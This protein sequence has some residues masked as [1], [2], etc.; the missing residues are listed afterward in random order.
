MEEDR[1]GQYKVGGSMASRW[2]PPCMH[3]LGSGRP[4]SIMR[5]LQATGSGPGV[6]W[7]RAPASACMHAD[8]SRPRRQAEAARQTGAGAGP[9]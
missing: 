4:V 3:A 1:P 6:A 9:S 7:C 2:N 8:R 5:N